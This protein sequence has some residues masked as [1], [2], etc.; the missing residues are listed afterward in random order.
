MKKEE[1]R[2]KKARLEAGIAPEIGQFRPLY[3]R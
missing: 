3:G 2:I 1:C